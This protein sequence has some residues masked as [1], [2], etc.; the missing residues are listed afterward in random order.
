MLLTSCQLTEVSD[1]HM[2]WNMI[3][4]MINKFNFLVPQN[5]DYNLRKLEEK[6]L[7]QDNIC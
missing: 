5:D 4:L 2:Y 3:K 1:M 6:I 7:I